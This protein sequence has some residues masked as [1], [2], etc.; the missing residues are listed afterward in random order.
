[1]HAQS[2]ESSSTSCKAYITESFIAKAIP[3]NPVERPTTG[4]AKVEHFPDFI[5]SHWK[6]YKGNA[7]YKIHWTYDCKNKPDHPLSLVISHINMAGKVYLNDDLLWKDQSLTEPLSRSWN[8]PR[9][10][11]IPISALKTKENTI[12]IYV[13]SASIQI[14]FSFG[15]DIPCSFCCIH[16]HSAVFRSTGCSPGYFQP[17]PWSPVFLSGALPI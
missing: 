12:W 5:N 3:N 4:W 11:Q 15:S 1:L 13:A 14:V 6:D 16:P 2:P 10:W 17:I 9:S 8:I 7:W